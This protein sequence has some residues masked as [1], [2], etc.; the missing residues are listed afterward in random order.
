MVDF[1]E[2][3]KMWALLHLQVTGPIELPNS[4]PQLRWQSG[5]SQDGLHM[6]GSVCLIPINRPFLGRLEHEVGRSSLRR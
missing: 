1:H 3:P 4:Q 2:S 5:A 6:E